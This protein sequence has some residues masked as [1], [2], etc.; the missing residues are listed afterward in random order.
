[1]G[2][3]S[4]GGYRIF[5]TRSFQ[6][7]IESVPQPTRTKLRNK[8][9]AAIYPGLRRQPHLGP[10]IRKLRDWKPETWRYRIGE[11]R[12][13]YEIDETERVVFL[14]ALHARKDSYR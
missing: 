4:A 1:M 3:A 6:A 2:E 9:Q 14:T 7:D 10:A 8:L 5:E 13:F 12:L 11:W